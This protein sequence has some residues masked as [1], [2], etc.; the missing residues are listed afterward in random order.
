VLS[1]SGFL[2]T[3]S[4][5]RMAIHGGPYGKSIRVRFKALKC[6]LQHLVLSF[7]EDS[8]G[9]DGDSC[10]SMAAFDRAREVISIMRELK[11][12]LS[13]P[14]PLLMSSSSANQKM[15]HASGFPSSPR[16]VHVGIN[17]DRHKERTSSHEPLPNL[18]PI[19][20]TLGNTSKVY[21]IF[22]DTL[23]ADLGVTNFKDLFSSCEE[24]MDAYIPNDYGR[25]SGRRYGFIRYV[26]I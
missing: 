1:G 4:P 15:S 26:D 23:S 6:E 20:E 14:L 17:G 8:I 16:F 13:K 11:G 12:L 5:N 9:Q 3:C 25:K 21:F 2:F 24:V 19:P 10:A 22:V 7:S 18:E